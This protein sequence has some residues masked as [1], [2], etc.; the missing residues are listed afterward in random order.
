MSSITERVERGAALLD[1]KRPGWWRRINLRRLDIRSACDCIAGQLGGY[2]DTLRALGLLDGEEDVEHGF[3][4]IDPDG[5]VL[6]GEYH[7]L[8]QEDYA[9]LTAAWHDLIGKRREGRLVSA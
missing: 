9:A 1:A 5:D 4:A 7:R 3:E 8:V 6:A 2:S